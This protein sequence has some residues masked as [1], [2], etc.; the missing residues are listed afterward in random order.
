MSAAEDAAAV[1]ENTS[2]AVE[3]IES[4]DDEEAFDRLHEAKDIAAESGKAET[5]ATLREAIVAFETGDDEAA[6]ESAQT[7]ILGTGLAAAMMGEE[8]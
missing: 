2:A 4:G 8:I 7:V 3:A 6:I 1:Y 5:L